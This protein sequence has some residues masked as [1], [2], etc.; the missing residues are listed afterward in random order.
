[1]SDTN[2]D[3]IIQSYRLLDKNSNM[4]DTRKDIQNKIIN[5]E[6]MK[7]GIYILSYFIVGMIIVGILNPKMIKTEDKFSFKKFLYVSSILSLGII[8]VNF[9]IKYIMNKI[10]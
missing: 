8:G 1:M 6:W 3:E 10:M 5:I 4:L 7:V 9:L 2:Y